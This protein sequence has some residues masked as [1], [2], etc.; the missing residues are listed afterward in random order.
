M[1]M[2]RL[3]LRLEGGKLDSSITTLD[4]KA[5][6]SLVWLYAMHRLRVIGLRVVGLRVVGLRVIGLRVI[7]LGVIG[8]RV[9]GLRVIGLRVIGLRV[10]GLGFG[11]GLRWKGAAQL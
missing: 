6:E 2:L 10:I 7:G 4:K 9:T 11:L 5:S 3:R 8:L 1:L